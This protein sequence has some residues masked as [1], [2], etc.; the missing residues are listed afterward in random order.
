MA[1]KKH[2][3]IRLQYV[4][5]T[6]SAFSIFICP[7]I[8]L[9]IIREYGANPFNNPNPIHLFLLVILGLYK[10]YPFSLFYYVFAVLE[11]KIASN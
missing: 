11:K 9:Y 6:L 3:L 4:N 7:V 5:I 8:Y 10:I 1:L 2:T